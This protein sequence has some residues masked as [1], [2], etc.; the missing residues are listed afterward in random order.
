MRR[1]NAQIELG[2]DC[3]RNARFTGLVAVAA[4][5][6]T[7]VGAVTG[8]TLMAKGSLRASR[9]RWSAVVHVRPSYVRCATCG[10]AIEETGISSSSAS[11]ETM[12]L[13]SS[14]ERSAD[15]EGCRVGGS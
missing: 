15:D 8:M 11:C 7:V 2:L 14:A 5:A 12:D 10:K 6:S 3:L 9:A 1:R 13:G 4:T